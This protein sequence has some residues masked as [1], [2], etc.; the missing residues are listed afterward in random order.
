MLT[1]INGQELFWAIMGQLPP[2]LCS[3]T[4]EGLFHQGPLRLGSR[5]WVMYLNFSFQ[6]LTWPLDHQYPWF[7]WLCTLSNTFIGHP[8]VSFL[9]DVRFYSPSPQIS[10]RVLPFGWTPV[11]SLSKII[12]SR[13]VKHR[14]P[15]S[16]R[17]PGMSDFLSLQIT[18]S[19]IKHLPLWKFFLMHQKSA[20]WNFHLFGI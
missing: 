17:P 8:F 14:F 19:I 5:N 4:F 2:G 3:L 7:V 13:P 18:D 1:W 15:A 10:K 9:R 12:L 6:W 11:S 20:S 16:W